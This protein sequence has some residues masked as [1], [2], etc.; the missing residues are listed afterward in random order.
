MKKLFTFLFVI[1]SLGLYSQ[2]SN[3]CLDCAISEGFYCG[4][5]PANWTVYS[6]D[7]CVPNGLGGLFYLNDGWEDCV[8]ASDEFSGEE[9]G[10]ETIATTIAECT[11]PIICDTVY[12]DVI[13]YIETFITDTIFV[14][15][16]I[17]DTLFVDNYITEF[18][19]VTDTVTI[20]SN[21]DTIFV[22]VIE[23]V[24]IIQTDTLF[25]DVIEY[26]TEYI[27]VF[28][29]DTLIITDTI[30]EI[31]YE[32]I[33]FTEYVDCDTGLP[34]ESGMEE[35]IE[36]SIEDNKLYNLNGQ[37]IRRPKG[38]YIEHGKIKYKVN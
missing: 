34:C 18:I 4:D 5:D 1:M 19:Y 10:A 15:N 38:V 11:D 28:V 13:E 3:N 31:E 8:D 16:F 17:L 36:K 24:E 22:P 30:I 12:V 21:A 2:E 20:Y 37:V 23:Y 35:I 33:I 26:I 29:T 9:G 7:G 14:D 6:P 25:I 27:E 32:E